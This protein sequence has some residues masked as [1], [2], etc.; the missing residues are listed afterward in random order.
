MLIETKNKSLRGFKIPEF[1]Y[2]LK[3]PQFIT[4]KSKAKYKGKH[5]FRIALILSGVCSNYAYGF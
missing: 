1:F 2:Y 5:T 3:N 4:S